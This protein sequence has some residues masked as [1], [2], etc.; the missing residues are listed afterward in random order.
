[1]EFFLVQL[2]ILYGLTTLR[3]LVNT[4]YFHTNL[5]VGVLRRGTF[6]GHG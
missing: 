1:M 4:C 5:P 6:N 3:F 2:S